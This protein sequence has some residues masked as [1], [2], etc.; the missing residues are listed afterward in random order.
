MK[1]YYGVYG[2]HP[3][4]HSTPETFGTRCDGCKYLECT[5]QERSRLHRWHY[6]CNKLAANLDGK[7]IWTI[8]EEQCPEHRKLKR[9]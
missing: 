3:P 7:K 6:Y 4:I 9:R 5:E 2:E 1:A 8:S